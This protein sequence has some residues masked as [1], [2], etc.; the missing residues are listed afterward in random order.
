MENKMPIIFTNIPIPKS[1]HGSGATKWPFNK[2]EVGHSFFAKGAALKSMRTYCAKQN[3][4]LAPK[5]FIARNYVIDSGHGP[6][7]G[8]MVWRTEDRSRRKA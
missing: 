7:Q 5:R 6:E 8:V 1:L 3:S 2:L 4:L